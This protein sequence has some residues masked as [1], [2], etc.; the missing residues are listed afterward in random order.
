MHEKKRV[1]SFLKTK[2]NDKNVINYTIVF[3]FNDDFRK[4]PNVELMHELIILGFLINEIDEP[5]K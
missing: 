5:G 4:Q 2:R 3:L 1:K